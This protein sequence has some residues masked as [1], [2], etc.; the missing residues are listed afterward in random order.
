VKRLSPSTRAV[1]WNWRVMP[2]EGVTCS[3]ICVELVTH[4]K[5]AM[6][7]PSQLTM[8][9]ML[10]AAWARMPERCSRYSCLSA[11]IGVVQAS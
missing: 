10:G 9:P 2:S 5:N 1:H 4:S 8:G 7:Y 6:A 11:S 3:H